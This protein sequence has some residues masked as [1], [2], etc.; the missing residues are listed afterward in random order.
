MYKVSTPT[1]TVYRNRIKSGE[2]GPA[3][4]GLKKNSNASK[5]DFEWLVKW[6]EEF[7]STHGQLVPLRVRKQKK[8]SGEIVKQVSKIPYTLLPAHYTWEELYKEMQGA[9]NQPADFRLPSASS[10]HRILTARCPTRMIRSPRDNV[11]DD[12]VMLRNAMKP[13]VSTSLTEQLGRHAIRA[14][15]MR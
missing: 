1:L 13:N 3:R 2:L 5:I 4:H 15:A 9:T 12:C 10:F 8:A 7:A 14:K 6:F 11:C